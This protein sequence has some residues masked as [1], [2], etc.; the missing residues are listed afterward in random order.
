MIDINLKMR[1]LVYHIYETHENVTPKYENVFKALQLANSDDVRVVI[2]GQDPY[3]TPG[4]ASGLA[5]GFNRDYTGPIDSSMLNITK[6]LGLDIKDV[7]RDWLTLESW[8]DQGVL[9]LNTRL[10]VEEGK[11]M[12]HVGLGWEPLVSEVLENLKDDN[13]DIVWLNWGSEAQ[14]M[15]P[16]DVINRIDTSHPCRFSNKSTSKPF[17]GSDCF[18][19]VNKLLKTSI[20]WCQL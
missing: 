14:K 13:K 5:F 1:K 11:P 7:T 6:E 2:L 8:S 19:R 15:C 16:K 18:Y 20:G 9:L 17:T 4:K 3:H 10:T 12:S